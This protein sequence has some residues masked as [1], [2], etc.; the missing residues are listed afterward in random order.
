MVRLSSRAALDLELRRQRA[1]ELAQAMTVAAVAA[2]APAAAAATAA[3]ATAAAAAATATAAAAATAVLVACSKRATRRVHTRSAHLL[4]HLRGPGA[5]GIRR[6]RLM[7]GDR[8]S[9]GA[10]GAITAIR[11]RRR[12]TNA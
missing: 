6:H 3:A 2:A 5:S 12:C 11:L 8:R 7:I 4:R 10:A 9:R 1:L